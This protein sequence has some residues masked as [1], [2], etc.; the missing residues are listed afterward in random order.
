LAVAWLAFASSAWAA[1]WQTTFAA[2]SDTVVFLGAQGELLSAPF[3][4]A[5]RETLW[6][7]EGPERVARF[8]VRPDGREVAWLTRVGDQGLTWLWSSSAPGLHRLVGYLPFQPRRRGVLRYESATPSTGDLHARGGRLIEPNAVMRRL[9]INTLEW[10]VDGASLAFGF[11]RGLAMTRADTGAAHEIQ[12]ALLLSLSLLDPAP[13]YLA[14]VVVPASGE[15][16]DPEGGEEFDPLQRPE[17]GAVSGSTTRWHLLYPTV[18]AWKLFDAATLD[19]RDPWTTDGSTVWWPD[20]KTIRAVR[21]HDPKPTVELAAETLVLWLGYEPGRQTLAWISG[22]DVQRRPAAGGEPATVMR[23]HDA[24]RRVFAGQGGRKFLVAGDS[25]IVWNPEDDSR[26]SI[27]LGSVDPSAAIESPSGGL[28]LAGSTRR[29]STAQLYRA[30][31]TSRKLV[32]LDV[33]KLKNGSLTATPSGERALWFKPES[34]A[35]GT[36]H[37]VDATTGSWSTVDNPGIVAWE[38]LRPR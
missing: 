16:R 9:S 28:L 32:T 5:T 18:P 24:C 36:L 35:P 11:D 26:S 10:S 4:L 19:G 1:D 23:L 21:A 8:V 14:E 6:A 17:P 20:G 38:F 29:G 22:R 13:F 37:V 12:P 7:P 2:E 27:G 3:H 25:L 31:F 33:P 30:D 15:P 34:K